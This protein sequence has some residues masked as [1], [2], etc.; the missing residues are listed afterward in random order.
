M[1]HTYKPYSFAQMVRDTQLDS[2]I[3]SRIKELIDSHII[4]VKAAQDGYSFAAYAGSMPLSRSAVLHI[5]TRRRHTVVESKN[6]PSDMLAKIAELLTEEA[7]I[8]GKF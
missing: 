3:V 8:F 7:R 4:F 2:R 1:T 5:H 6:M